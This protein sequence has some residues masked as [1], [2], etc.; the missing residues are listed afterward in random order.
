[1]ET[2]QTMYTRLPANFVAKY[3]GLQYRGWQVLLN[4]LLSEEPDDRS[5]I[6]IAEPKGRIG[7]NTF[8]KKYLVENEENSYCINNVGK[9]GDAADGLRNWMSGGKEPRTVII[10]LSRSREETITIYDLIECL[11]D[12]MMTC[13]KYKGETKYFLAPHVVVFSNWLPEFE[14]EIKGVM[15]ATLTED[16]WKIF[17]IKD[18]QLIQMT[19][20]EAKKAKNNET[21][22][23]KEKETKHVTKQL[24]MKP[25]N[26]THMK[27]EYRLCNYQF[28]I[29]C[30]RH[31]YNCNNNVHNC[32][33]HKQK[34][35][36]EIDIDE[37]SSECSE[38]D[39]TND[40]ACPKH[41]Y[42]QSNHL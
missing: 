3:K 17:T 4:K 21:K 42:S 30:E 31:C 6:W 27:C 32:Q 29:P 9:L 11:K 14:R 18:D 12:E 28:N 24:P 33:Y 19:I 16:R 13:T 20:E 1:M 38:C 23:E 5:I 34:A 10:N 41:A 39:N 15:K 25:C 37:I 2:L 36:P 22:Q 7:K 26:G 35:Y 40:I 8:L